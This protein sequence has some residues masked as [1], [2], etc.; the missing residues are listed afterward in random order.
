MSVNWI[1]DWQDL[2]TE[3]GWGITLLSIS[4]MKFSIKDLPIN[5]FTFIVLGVGVRISRGK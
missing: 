5:G 1:N 3:L 4:Y 2:S